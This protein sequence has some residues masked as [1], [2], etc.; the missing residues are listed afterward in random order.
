MI[1]LPII[2]VKPRIVVKSRVAR[3]VA[4]LVLACALLAAGESRAQAILAMA[5]GDPITAFDVEQRIKLIKLTE[6]RTATPKE[7]LEIL[8]N[9]RLKVK[10][11]RKY[12]LELS[13]SDLDEQYNDMARRLRMPPE[14]LTKALESQGI[15][16]DTLKARI[17]ADITWTQL[18]RGRYQQALLVGEKEVQLALNS[19]TPSD[20]KTAESSFEYSMRPVVLLVTGGDVTVETR[21]KEAEALRAK[22]QTCDEAAEIFRNLRSAVI[23]DSVSKT[24]ADLPPA[25]RTLLDT[26]PVGH[27]TPPEVTR[28]GIEM[29]ALCERKPT[30]DTPEKKK[31][32]DE[33]Y[34][35]KYEIQAKKYLD[36]LRRGAMI[37]YR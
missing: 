3:L 15:R 14:Q 22:V 17:K 4:G 10:E 11:G 5:N 35:K 36:S 13:G 21:R 1:G 20:S 29:V 28:Q 31:V 9:D 7:V 18:V 6:H 16:P 12:G 25:L 26:T 23:R 34:A 24:S 33:L 27:L 37:E 30:T 32:R 2:V 8:I 19:S